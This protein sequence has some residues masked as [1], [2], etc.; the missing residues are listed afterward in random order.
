MAEEPIQD[1]K[2]ADEEFEDKEYCS[3]CIDAATEEAN[4]EPKVS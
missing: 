2:D 1:P 3:E 4:E